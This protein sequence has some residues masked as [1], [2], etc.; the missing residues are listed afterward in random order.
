M[1]YI[2]DFRQTLEKATPLLLQISP[3]KAAEKSAPEKWSI[4]EIIGH[5]IDSASNNHQ[6]FVRAN[7]QEEFIFQGYQQVDWVKIQDY[8]KADWTFLVNFWKLYNQHLANVME[9]IPA[10]VR[11]KVHTKHNLHQIGM[12]KVEKEESVTLDFFME[13]YVFHLK[14]HLGQIL[15]ESF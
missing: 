2:N 14:H 11:L 10:E 12:R 7:L 9:A 4:K 8:Q 13:D 5:L 1:N 3:E 6:R 15:K